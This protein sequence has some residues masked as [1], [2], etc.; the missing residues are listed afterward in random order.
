MGR[1]AVRSESGGGALRGPQAAKEAGT[2]LFLES[3]IKSLTEASETVWTL[4][5]GK[6]DTLVIS[7]AR[8]DR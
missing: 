2:Q 6:A 1:K 8:N 7:A 3:F 5:L 4:Q